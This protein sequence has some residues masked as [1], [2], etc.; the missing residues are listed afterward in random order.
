VEKFSG[1]L[2]KENH[3]GMM[4]W[5]NLDEAIQTSTD[6]VITAVL[7]DYQNGKARELYYK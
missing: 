2:I 1:E 6:E 7:S 3:E 5:M 4:R